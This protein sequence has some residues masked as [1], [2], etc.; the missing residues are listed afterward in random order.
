MTQRP[1]AWTPA[2]V[3]DVVADVLGSGESAG[4]Y[5][6]ATLAAQI[7][8]IPAATVWRWV[9]S[10]T[11][12]ETVSLPPGLLVCR[13]CAQPMVLVDLPQHEPCYSCRSAC[14]RRPLPASQIST[15]I[16]EAMLQRVPQLVPRG[17]THDAALYA[18]GIIRRITVGA[19]ATDLH[20]T[21]HPA[22]RRLHRP[23][24]TTRQRLDLARQRMDAGDMTDALGLLETGLR[25]IDPHRTGATARDETTATVAVLY[26]QILLTTH[27]ASTAITWAAYGHRSLRKFLGDHNPTTCHALKVLAAAHRHAGH[28]SH[29]ADL[30]AELAAHLH[31]MLGPRALPTIAAHATHALLLFDS[32]DCVTARQLLANTL[33]A[34]KAQRREHPDGPR[35]QHEL[36]R[37][38]RHCL[39]SKHR[40][41]I[42]ADA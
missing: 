27:R 10:A 9:A 23:D 18:P 32:G 40:H 39:N 5:R 36:E 12:I 4:L 25:Q 26:A 31:R 34:H 19:T 20:I 14:P 22:P 15:L 28:T 11:G 42:D 21:W 37:M 16:A 29:A 1:T 33:A 2:F 8:R 13:L 35:M 7:H 6:A 41:A 30:Y 17:R 38:R 3:A 24:L